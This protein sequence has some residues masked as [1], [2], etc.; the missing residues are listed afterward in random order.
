M[1][2]D[3]PEAVAYCN[4]VVRPAADRLAQAYYAAKS[5][6]NTWNANNYGGTIIP[7]GGG[8]VV[9]GSATDGRPAITGND[10]HNLINRLTEL[11]ADYEASS[12]AKLNTVLNVSPNPIRQ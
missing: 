4:T 1:P 8:E 5:A 3:N 7:V 11:V 2:I 10:V 6:V 9:D 12:N